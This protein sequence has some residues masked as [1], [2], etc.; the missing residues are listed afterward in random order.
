MELSIATLFG[1]VQGIAE[2]LPISSS[3][4]LVLLHDVLGVAPGGST[5]A[6]DVALHWGTLVA[7]LVYFARDLR[8]LIASFFRSLTKAPSRWNADARLSWYIALGTIPAV[9]VGLL[10]TETGFE[11]VLRTP[12]L[13]SLALLAVGA[14][15]LAVEARY[16]GTKELKDI[17]LRIALIIGVAQAVA[18]FPGV[19]RSGITIITAM[20]LG[21]TRPAGAR[22]SFLLSIPAVLG[23]G[24]L[25]LPDLLGIGG[26]DWRLVIAGFLGAVFS[27][28]LALRFLFRWFSRG[29]TMR[30]YAWY[31]IG[32]AALLLVL[33]ASFR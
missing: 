21:L 32:L 31:R 16:R 18:L 11:E 7:L 6:F 4:H 10:L 25:T 27:G 30:P 8:A 9:F 19:S 2:F 1:I 17:T 22:F 29:V 20:A 15:F 3:G 13:V 14:V 24:V 23:A 12:L 28:L 33:I 26:G 5:V